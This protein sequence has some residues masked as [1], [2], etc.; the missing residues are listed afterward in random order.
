[1]HNL[2]KTLKILLLPILTTFSVLIATTGCSKPTSTYSPEVKTS[3][4][5][6]LLNP[7]AQPTIRVVDQN[8]SPVEN[9]QILVGLGNETTG[10]DLINTDK[11]GVAVVQKNW[12][13]EQHVTVQAAGFIRQTLLNQK[14][15]SLVVKLN[16]AYQNP[17]P[18]VKGQVTGLPVVNGDK[19]IDF[20]I[21]MPT[22][23]KADLLNFDLGAV[24]SPYSDTLATPGRDS[25]IPS[26]VVIPTQ[27]E[28]Y[29]IGV[30]L[31]KPDHRLYMTTYGQKTFFA[32]SGRFPFKTIIKE[33]T[34]G[35]EFYEILNHFDF[36]S[37]A[38]KDHM[39]N[40]SVT[41]MNMSGVDF[42]FTGL[43]KVKGGNIAA[44]DVL[45]GM[46]ASDLNGQFIPS[47]IK[48]LTAG[49]ITNFK[50]LTGKPTF[51]VSLMKKKSDFS[52]QSAESDRSSASIVPYSN[53][54]TTSLL[55]LINAPV[56][57]FNNEAYRIQL[58]EQPRTGINQEVIHPIAVTAA[59]SDMIQ[60]PD[61]QTTVTILNRKWEI[62]G[63]SWGSEIQLP[64]WP[65]ENQ[66]SKKRVEINLIG[67]TAKE[68]VNIGTDLVEAAT[69]VTHSATEY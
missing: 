48:T 65:L 16:L 21:V 22:I 36:T 47:D 24:L 23:S 68:S 45:L 57:T 66:P 7:S 10:L 4:W 67:S 38:I 2:S 53:E 11:N 32:L 12:T 56:V 26:N 49:K 1:M 55:P 25:T 27:K 41:T 54:V 19:N 31:S 52:Q 6:A 63:T 62:V 61:Q 37:G 60:I 43:A 35:K 58:P 69:H 40:A 29:F 9:A 20:S 8:N 51:V 46:T 42:K 3:S 39:V 50:T 5:F 28:S 64:S 14:P 44:D 17:R 59:L 18:M 30:T 13:T 15:G 33:L 34:D